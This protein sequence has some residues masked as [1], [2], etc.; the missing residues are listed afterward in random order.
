MNIFV[1]DLDPTL[2]ARD[3]ADRHVVKMILETTQILSTVLRLRGVDDPDLYKITHA[4][5]PSV[6]WAGASPVNTAWAYRH[7]RDLAEEYTVRYGKI[8]AC[9]RTLGQIARHD[10]DMA[11]ISDPPRDFVYVGPAEHWTGD[12]PTSYRTYLKAKYRTWGDRA[13]WRS[14]A[15]KPAWM[16]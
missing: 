16:E 4:S 7:A 14:P 3:L 9:E 13:R 8:H 6:V 5:H 12:V 11:A 15:Q 2:S 1:T 10:P